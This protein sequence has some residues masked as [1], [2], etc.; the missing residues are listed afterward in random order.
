MLDVRPVDEEDF[1]VV[2]PYKIEGLLDSVAHGI[3]LEGINNVEG[4][5]EGG[6]VVEE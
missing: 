3:A 1:I 5:H 4:A 2:V 6:G